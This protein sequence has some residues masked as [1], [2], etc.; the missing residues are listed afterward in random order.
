M[1]ALLHLDLF[2]M[3]CG[4]KNALRLASSKMNV[5]LHPPV[6]RSLRFYV[7]LIL[8]LNPNLDHCALIGL[9]PMISRPCTRIYQMR[10]FKMSCAN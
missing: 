3:P 10:L 9:K 5:G 6:Q 7:L 2:S 8:M 4:V 1:L